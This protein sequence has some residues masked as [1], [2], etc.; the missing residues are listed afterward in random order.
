MGRRSS[1]HP[2]GIHPCHVLF[3]AT[4]CQRLLFA[5][6]WVFMNEHRSL[7]VYL[8]TAVGS[9]APCSRIISVQ[10]MFYSRSAL[11]ATSQCA[12]PAE[13]RPHEAVRTQ[14]FFGSLVASDGH[15]PCVCS[16]RAWIRRCTSRERVSC[17]TMSRGRREGMS[18]C[19]RW[20][21]VVGWWVVVRGYNH[22][23]NPA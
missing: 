10:F 14:S 11:R 6:D 9:Q 7:F 4:I 22:G 16:R 20:E 12:C 2:L 3:R 1:S 17:C 15:G 23:Y 21:V 19:G 5:W 8:F 13:P 18:E